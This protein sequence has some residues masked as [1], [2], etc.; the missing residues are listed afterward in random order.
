[1]TNKEFI[2]SVSLSGEEWRDLIG[3]DGLY[4]ISSYGR[5]VSFSRKNP[6]LMKPTINIDKTGYKRYMYSV[7]RNN[8]K[9][10]FISHRL[11]AIHFIPN[12]FNYPEVDHID[13]D[14][15]NNRVDNLRWCDHKMNQENQTTRLKLSQS[16]IGKPRL[17]QR[18]PIVR[19]FDSKVVETYNGIC[20]TTKQGF[21]QS[22]VS[23]CC[24]NVA[25]S[26]KGF[27]FMF[28]SDY[29]ALIKSKN[30]AIQSN[31]N[32]QQEQPPQL[33]ELQLPLQFEP[34]TP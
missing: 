8:V 16:M 4:C 12:P 1:M 10:T 5:M 19:L 14:S 24:R 13:S 27:Q 22:N 7:K 31:D 18:K 11:V 6:I 9:K 15:L 17:K 25:K 2:K 21:I 26:H 33:Q 32:Y 30:E 3:Y 34:Q 29:E 20:E 28:L 23:A